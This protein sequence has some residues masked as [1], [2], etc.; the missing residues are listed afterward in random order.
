MKFAR[1]AIFLVVAAAAAI[2]AQTPQTNPLEPPVIAP[3]PSVAAAKSEGDNREL[4]ASI[5]ALAEL[6]ASNA[7]L[8]QKQ[9]NT[10]QLL[11]QLSKEADQLRIFSKRG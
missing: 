10:L 6:R 2:F 8:L 9:Q 5:Q 1:L 11:D 7:E 4:A 3:A